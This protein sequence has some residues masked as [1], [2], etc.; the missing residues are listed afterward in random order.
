VRPTTTEFA[1]NARASSG[2]SVT[3]DGTNAA[4]TSRP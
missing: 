4:M 1:Q 3:G 2:V